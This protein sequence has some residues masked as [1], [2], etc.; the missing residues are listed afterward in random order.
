[1]VGQGQEHSVLPIQASACSNLQNQDGG[2]LAKSGNAQFC[3][4]EHLR[5]RICRTE[6]GGGQPRVGK[7]L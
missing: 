2:W 1:M 6:V 7:V 5:A 3:Q 4:F